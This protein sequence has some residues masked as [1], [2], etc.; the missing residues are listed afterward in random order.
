VRSQ[1]FLGGGSPLTEV[2]D[3][4][5]FS[6]HEARRGFAK[7]QCNVTSPLIQVQMRG[8]SSI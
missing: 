6:E 3:G 8:G 7:R 2:S 4:L 1:G 5:E